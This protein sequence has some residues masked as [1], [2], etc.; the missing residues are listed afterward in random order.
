VVAARFAWM[1]WL[2]PQ[3]SWTCPVLVSWKQGNEQPLKEQVLVKRLLDVVM[4]PRDI[5]NAAGAGHSPLETA[6]LACCRQQK[7]WTRP[8]VCSKATIFEHPYQVKIN[9]LCLRKHIR[10]VLDRNKPLSYRCGSVREDFWGAHLNYSNDSHVMTRIIYHLKFYLHIPVHV[11]CHNI[12]ALF[13]SLAQPKRILDRYG[14]VVG[15]LLMH[16]ICA[17]FFSYFGIPFCY[18][19]GS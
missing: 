3:K 6:S 18:R 9:M 12:Y 11:I 17:I 19:F 10:R 1:A 8:V 14:W 13:L 15:L 7:S 5:N 2:L 4:D 16:K